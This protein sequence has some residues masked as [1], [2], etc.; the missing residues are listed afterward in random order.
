MYPGH[1]QVPGR[2]PRPGGERCR[3]VTIDE[4]KVNQIVADD[5]AQLAAVLPGIGHQQHLLAR[6][7]RG[8]VGAAGIL[9][10]LSLVAAGDP[11]AL[12]AGLQRALVALA[13]ENGKTVR[14]VTHLNGGQRRPRSAVPRRNGC[15]R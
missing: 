4:A 13:Q 3:A 8:D 10:Q 9:E 2:G 5:P 14:K 11:A 6:E 15:V 7:P 1:D 12:V